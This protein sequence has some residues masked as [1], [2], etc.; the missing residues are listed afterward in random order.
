MKALQDQPIEL[1]VDCTYL[2]HWTNGL[3]TSKFKDKSTMFTVVVECLFFSNNTYKVSSVTTRLVGAIPDCFTG[4]MT[5]FKNTTVVQSGRVN[6]LTI[7][8]QHNENTD[9]R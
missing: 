8:P 1:R 3:T 5:L 7:L 4:R 6:L 2:T 9:Q